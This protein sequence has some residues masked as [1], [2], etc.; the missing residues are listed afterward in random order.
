MN[1]P[2]PPGEILKREYIEKNN[3]TYIEVAKGLGITKAKL[4]EIVNEYV[5]ITPI[6][7]IRLGKAFKTT[8]EYWLDL[9]NTYE[10][11]HANKTEDKISVRVFL[12]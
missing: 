2:T 6:V 7:A 3:L 1:T 10:L 12:I 8:A 5:R 9:Q 11:W 4:A